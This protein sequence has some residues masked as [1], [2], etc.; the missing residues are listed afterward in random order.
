[1]ESRT[2]MTSAVYACLD[3]FLC[4]RSSQCALVHYA[5]VHCQFV[6]CSALRLI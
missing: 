5:D 3:E 1:M 4:C 2:D 6:V